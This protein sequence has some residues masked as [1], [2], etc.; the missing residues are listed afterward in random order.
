MKTQITTFV[1]ELIVYDFILFGSSFILFILLII[2]G[3]LLR[4]KTAI[5]VVV[6]LLSFG[7]LFLAPTFGYVKMHEY[8]YKHKTEL[9][10]EKKLNFNNAIVVKG[11]LT[12]ESKRFFKRCSIKASAIKVTSNKFKNYIFSFK[13]IVTSKITEKNIDIGES[14]EF[15]IIVEP[16]NYEG[17]YNITIGAK[18]N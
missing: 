15:K 13:P 7:I 18:C 14:R 2:L 6:I 16:F 3:I 17:D 11:L 10:S 9:L 4:R 1:N 12:N 8:L 5:A